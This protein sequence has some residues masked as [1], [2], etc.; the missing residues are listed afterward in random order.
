MELSLNTDNMF[1]LFSIL[2]MVRYSVCLR[3]GIWDQMQ[4]C[5]FA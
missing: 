4:Q 5:L 3:Q 2:K 1:L